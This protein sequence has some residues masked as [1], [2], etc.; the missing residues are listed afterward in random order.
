MNNKMNKTK[1]ASLLLLASIGSASFASEVETHAETDS[2]ASTYWGLGIGSVLGGIIAGP[3]G[4]A[5]G[6]SLG[7]ALGWGQDQN[8][9]L[10]QTQEQLAENAS[11]VS[12]SKSKLNRQAERL[13]AATAHIGE[14]KRNHQS[15]LKALSELRAEL[16]RKTQ[17][18]EKSDLASVLDAYSQEL[19][20]KKGEAQLPD[21]ADQRISKLAD[22]LNRYP[23]LQVTL[24]GYTDQSGPAS[25]NQKLSQARAEGVKDALAE[26]GISRER[27]LIQSAGETNAN[28]A[29]SD[30][31]NAIL[32]RR[33]AIEFSQP[34]DQEL[35]SNKGEQ[36]L[37]VKAI[38]D[39]ALAELSQ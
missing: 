26:K 33:V 2:Q 20:F 14:L 27:I 22:F 4:I 38:D 8:E 31:G 9:A 24:T 10:E 32:D 6:A 29:E 19:Y 12:D 36:V 35:I 15:Q 17:T 25:F 11:L 39:T 7:G 30:Q 18:L 3:P 1:V 37:E 16:E 21:Y 13:S 34:L 28:V 23:H 5:I